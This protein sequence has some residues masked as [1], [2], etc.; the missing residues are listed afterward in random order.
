MFVSS[1]I[2]AWTKDGELD[3]YRNMLTQ[4][5]VGVWFCQQ[6]CGLFAR[7]CNTSHTICLFLSFQQDRWLVSVIAT[8]SGEIWVAYEED[9]EDKVTHHCV[10]IC[11]GMHVTS[12]GVRSLRV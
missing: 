8:T 4:V 11:I 12:T 10:C 2:T 3:A 1:T 5:L 7:M 6:G 9:K